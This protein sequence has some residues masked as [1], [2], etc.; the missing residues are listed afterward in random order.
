MLTAAPVATKP[1]APLGTMANPYFTPAKGLVTREPEATDEAAPAP[2][3]VPNPATNAG[4]PPVS[5]LEAANQ[6]RKAGNNRLAGILYK[7]IV[8][9]AALDRGQRDAAQKALDE[10]KGEA[11]KRLAVIEKQLNVEQARRPSRKLKPIYADVSPEDQELILGAFDNLEGLAREYQGVPETGKLLTKRLQE[12]REEPRFAAALREP[13]AAMFLAQGNTYE[14]AKQPCCAML[15]YEEAA[16]SLPAASARQAGER[17]A[18]LR[19]DPDLVAAANRCRTLRACHEL[20]ARAR[21]WQ[22]TRDGA[23]QARL[24]YEQVLATAPAGSKVTVAARERLR[25]LPQAQ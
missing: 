4:A 1:N 15:C 19:R 8:T 5:K 16:L 17:L 25:Q 21:G 11:L 2:A 12:L 9:T 14:K 22:K 7:R 23:S 24:L 6:A 18:E 13:R 20:Y 3:V 10:M